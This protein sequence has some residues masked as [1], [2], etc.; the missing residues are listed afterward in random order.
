M[1]RKVFMAILLSVVVVA[2][3]Y[4]AFRLF[5]PFLLSI[6]WAAVLAA[7]T[8]GG[9]TRLAAR[10]GGRRGLAALLMTFLVAIL[11][12]A[13]FVLLIV[14]LVGDA[15]AWVD[16]GRLSDTLKHV[17]ESSVAV[18]ARAWVEAKLHEPLA[19]EKIAAFAREKVLS[20]AAG[21]F[22]AVQFLF[23]LLSG[24]VMMLL[25][26]FFFY[27]D[28]PAIIS[29]FR[30]LI[31]L[32]D[33][34]RNEVLDDVNGAIQASVRGGLLVALVQGVLGF[35]ILLI[36]GVG[37]PVMGA[38]AMAL[39]SFIPLV[40]TTTIWL[41]IALYLILIAGDTVRGF[42][43]AGYGAIVIGGADNLVRPL[44]LGRHMEAHPL[45]LFLGVLG[46]LALFG[47]A[48]IVLGPIVVAFLNV[49]TRLL[50]RRF[51]AAE[52]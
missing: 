38:A 5:E 42:V 43:L 44:F 11:V 48:G 29:S 52:A 12:V 18:D 47:F 27:R 36:L 16:S 13:P 21:A 31:P 4:L 20:V 17:M 46:G 14:V 9:Q 24:V 23:G 26:L 25:C 2:L 19:V 1:D 7:V 30:G 8:Y 35:V 41:P 50:R 28:G 22:G 10:L 45:M 33:E 37:K 34:D 6:L 39:A 51:T 3:V 32:T 49:A 40:G 15:V